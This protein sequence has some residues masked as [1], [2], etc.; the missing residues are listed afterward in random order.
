MSALDLLCIFL[1]LQP[2]LLEL[3]FGALER[4]LI[5]VEVP[6][7]GDLVNFEVSILFQRLLIEFASALLQILFEEVDL[8]LQAEVLFVDLFEPLYITRQ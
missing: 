7:H 5:R 6:R 8:E 4:L 3:L 2:V 1:K